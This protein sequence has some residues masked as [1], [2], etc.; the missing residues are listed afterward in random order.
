MESSRGR[1]KK[2]KVIEKETEKADSTS[3]QSGVTKPVTIP[4]LS[5]KRAKTK[6]QKR[7]TQE[8]GHQ[9]ATRRKFSELPRLNISSDEVRMIWVVL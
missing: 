8:P 9:Y 7:C 4:L 3:P 1:G 5:K 2:K 6:D